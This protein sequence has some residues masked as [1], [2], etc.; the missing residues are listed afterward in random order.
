MLV[1][2]V[3]GSVNAF[4]SGDVYIGSGTVVANATS[5]VNIGG[6]YTQLAGGT[7]EIDRQRHEGI[8]GI[9]V[10]AG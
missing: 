2:G 3:A 1:M 8:A 6:K 7:L 10:R 4:G 5:R 9:E